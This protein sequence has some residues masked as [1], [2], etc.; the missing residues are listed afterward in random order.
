MRKK[1]AVFTRTDQRHETTP[2]AL[3]LRPAMI[4]E[5]REREAI[6]PDTI[7]DRTLLA[8][9]FPG[10]IVPPRPPGHHERARHGNDEERHQALM[11]FH[12]VRNNDLGGRSR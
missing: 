12:R 11:P 5:H 4:N 7:N 8:V 1:A 6:V 3:F 10:V 9:E 2:G